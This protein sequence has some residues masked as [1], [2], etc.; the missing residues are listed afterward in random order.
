[1]AALEAETPLRAVAMSED[2]ERKLRG[3]N[4]LSVKPLLVVLNAGESDA[5]SLDAVIERSGL[6]EFA[7]RPK[8][9]IAAAAAQIE[10]EIAR[11]D[12]ADARTFMDD[13]GLAESALVRLI[14]TSYSLLGLVSFFTAGEDECRAWTIRAGTRAQQAAGT[15][16]SDIERGFIRAEVVSCEE[17]FAA[18]SFAAAREKA[19]LRLEGKDYP[20]KDGDVAHFRFNV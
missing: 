7:T 14:R 6:G 10:M 9:A 11:L 18:G 5:G 8:V 2:D 1:V 13:L 15:I 16:H 12:P 17:L 20:V 19:K 4:F 3:F